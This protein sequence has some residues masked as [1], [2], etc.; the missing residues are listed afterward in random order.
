MQEY[1][2]LLKMLKVAN[3]NVQILHRHLAG[4]NWFGNH[5]ILG[6]YYEHIQNDIDELCELGMSID[7]T[8]PTIQESLSVYNEFEIK[9]RDSKESFK[10]IKIIFDDIIAQINRISSLNPDVINKLQE[11]QTYYRVE[12]NYK[13]K[14]MINE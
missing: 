1:I 4:E 8:E 3:I 14:A 13:I 6:E 11:K 9:Y 2:E 7:I 12:A 10:E 5:E